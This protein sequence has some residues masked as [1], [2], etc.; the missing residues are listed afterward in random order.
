[1]LVILL[2]DAS[3]AQAQTGVD[4]CQ[5]VDE[6]GEC[7]SSIAELDPQP[8]VDPVVKGSSA[9][10]GALSGEPAPPV[11]PSAT[12]TSRPDIEVLPDTGGAQIP[13]LAGGVVLVVAGLVA[14]RI[15]R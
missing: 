5:Y 6:N 9:L 13:A 8:F 2:A 1:M 14:R 7:A 4:D 10:T 11:V 3:L 15:V 12:S